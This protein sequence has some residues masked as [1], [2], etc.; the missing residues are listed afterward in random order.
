MAD[1]PDWY[2]QVEGTLG[3]ASK[4][5]SGADANKAASPI[6]GDVYLATDTSLMYV[7][8]VTGTWESFTIPLNSV[9]Q[10]QPTRSF[11]VIYHHTGTKIKLVVVVVQFTLGMTLNAYG[12]VEIRCDTG[13]TP[14]T[15]V[16]RAKMVQQELG[17]A[18]TEFATLVF[19]VPPDYY[20]TAVSATILSAAVAK[21]AWTES[22]IL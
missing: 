22:D 21:Y 3:T 20:Y 13:V 17:A 6:A 7:C 11:D 15:P 5:N 4:I 10:T 9:S 16:A 19:L 18:V 2:S 8:F 14:S 12:N 1:L